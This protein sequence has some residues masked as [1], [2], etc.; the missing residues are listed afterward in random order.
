MMTE[1]FIYKANYYAV[2]KISYE[3]Q[4]N[5]VWIWDILKLASHKY[6]YITV[7]KNFKSCKFSIYLY[8]EIIIIQWNQ[9]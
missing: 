3:Y 5:M 2:Q 6:Y 8:I 7:I 4:I 9:A 1:C